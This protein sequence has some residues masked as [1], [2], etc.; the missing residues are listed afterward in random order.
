[1]TR[2]LLR[3]VWNRKRQ[4]LLL[5]IE[6]FLSFLVLFVVAFFA[7]TYYSNWRHPLGFEFDRVWTISV[8]SPFAGPPQPDADAADVAGHRNAAATLAR[9]DAA[10]RGLS[11]VEATAGSWPSSP[12]GGGGW[13]TGVGDPAIAQTWMNF[14]TDD[15]DDTL[16]I[17]VTAGRWF[18]R[19]DDAATFQ[20]VVINERLATELFGAAS[21]VNQEI[22]PLSFRR[23]Q[24]LRVIGVI[25]D[26]RHEG[27]LSMPGN[28]VFLRLPQYDAD[29]DGVLPNDL[30]VRVAPGTTADFEPVLAKTLEQIA[31]DWTFEIRPLDVEREI[32]LRSWMSPLITVSIVAAFL[33]LMVGLGLIGVVWQSVTRRT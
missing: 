31:P 33:L 29:A 1:M 16:G 23:N 10:L 5:T 26:F 28:Y 4:N 11:N 32:V 17:K 13:N 2:H 7:F 19:E 24:R 22:P 6:I 25:D 15:F 27:E 3:L 8:P 14:A 12:Y 21:P 9:I 18:S 20:P 30:V